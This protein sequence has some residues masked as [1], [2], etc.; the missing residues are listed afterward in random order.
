MTKSMP[1]MW[2]M[3]QHWQPWEGGARNE[4][5]PLLPMMPSGAD[6]EAPAWMPT[7]EEY[8]EMRALW[9]KA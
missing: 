3:L 5:K 2:H 6:L 8:H 7:Q 4:L 9:K 1:N